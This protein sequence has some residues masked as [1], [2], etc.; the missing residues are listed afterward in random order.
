MGRKVTT[1]AHGKGGI[2]A[3]VRA[4]YDSIEHGMWA[5]EE[6]LRLMKQHGTYL[7]PT[8]WP[9]TWVGD[10]PEKVLRGPMKDINPASLSKL[11]KLGDPPKRLVRM[12]IEI[13][14]PIALGPASGLAPPGT[15][16]QAV[17]EVVK[18][19]TTQRT[20]AR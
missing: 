19:G 10:T 20:T 6:S 17:A 8:V 12:A 2:D 5:D 9:I 14:T 15:T 1:H 7:I 11:L 4:G 18:A 16:P 13:G 3:A